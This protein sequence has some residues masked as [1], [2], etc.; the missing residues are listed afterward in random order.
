MTVTGQAELDS[1]SHEALVTVIASDEPFGVLSIAPSSL[2]VL[3]E[4]V[5]T[6]IKIFITR[7]QGA[8]GESP[9]NGG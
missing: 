3:S 2:S 6:T 8:S 4:E 9:Q 5:N 7:D 1:E